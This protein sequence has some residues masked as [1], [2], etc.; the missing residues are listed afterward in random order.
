MHEIHRLLS[1]SSQQKTLERL[2]KKK[3][4]QQ[5]DGGAYKRRAGEYIHE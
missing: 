2:K 1:K 5:G 4:Y 3:N